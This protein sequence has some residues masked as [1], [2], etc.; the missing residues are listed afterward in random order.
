MIGCGQG[1]LFMGRRVLYVRVSSRGWPDL[2]LVVTEGAQPLQCQN[3]RDLL[4]V[5]FVGD[6]ELLSHAEG[7]GFEQGKEPGTFQRLRFNEDNRVGQFHVLVSSNE[8][9]VFGNVTRE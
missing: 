9:T 1:G 2:P 4:E 5:R 7:R 6:S 8:V 3:V